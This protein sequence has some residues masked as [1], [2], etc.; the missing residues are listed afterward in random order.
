MP[1]KRCLSP[2]H[3]GP[4]TLPLT[5]F[6]KN[7]RMADGLRS[8]C[9]ACQ[10]QDGR[11]CRKEK[12]EAMALPLVCLVCGGP[13]TGTGRPHLIAVCRKNPAC[14]KINARLHASKARQRHRRLYPS[15]E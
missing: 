6:N 4:N 8:W 10:A 13:L 15:S 2:D 1:V 7:A 9:R 5:E 14:A 3:E 12:R 11:R